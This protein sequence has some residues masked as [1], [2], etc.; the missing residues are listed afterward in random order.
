LENMIAEFKY[1]FVLPLEIWV[2][3]DDITIKWL[4]SRRCYCR[5]RHVSAKMSKLQLFLL[6]KYSSSSV[7]TYERVKILQKCRNRW[8]A[9]VY[10][11]PCTW[12]QTAEDGCRPFLTDWGLPESKKHDI[13]RQH[14]RPAHNFKS[15]LGSGHIIFN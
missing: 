5:W 10:Y 11:N 1:N 14:S 3:Q 9:T 12:W 8:A 6:L 13:R 15:G 2:L 7:V 4:A